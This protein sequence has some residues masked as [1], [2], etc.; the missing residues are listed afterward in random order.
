MQTP[1]LLVPFP[2]SRL[3]A[4][5]RAELDAKARQLRAAG[6]CEFKWIPEEEEPDDLALAEIELDEDDTDAAPAKP[7]PAPHRTPRG[8]VA[9]TPEERQAIAD[10]V[11]ALRRDYPDLA[12]ATILCMVAS[13][14]GRDKSTVR[15]WHRDANGIAA[16]A[17]RPS[18]PEERGAAVREVEA[19]LRA[20]PHMCR[21]DAYRQVG[22]RVGRPPNTVSKWYHRGQRGTL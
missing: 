21:E 3:P 17:V 9:S 10:R 18:T 7:A 4:R 15:R 14:T 5:L 1:D 12:H 20:D 11:E 22:A 8:V 13:E 16:L 19:L 2:R 6:V